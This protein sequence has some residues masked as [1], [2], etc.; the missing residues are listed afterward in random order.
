M[1]LYIGAFVRGTNRSDS[2]L[3]ADIYVTKAIVTR[4]DSRHEK[5]TRIK[6]LEHRNGKYIGQEFWVKSEDLE[7]LEDDE[8]I[9]NKD[10]YDVYARL[11]NNGKV[12]CLLQASIT[13]KSDITKEAQKLIAAILRKENFRP[14]L[15]T[16]KS[17]RRNHNYPRHYGFIGDPTPLT[18][19]MGNP[20]FVGDEVVYFKPDNST[21]VTYTFVVCDDDN[22]SY[23]IPGLK[24]NLFSD[25]TMADHTVVKFKSY[26]KIRH[27]VEVDGI[28]AV[29]Q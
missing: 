19:S 27:G 2:C 29:M 26:T 7:L 13:S 10:E 22:G 3:Y 4:I 12:I 8:I 23:Y 25:G 20:L 21:I 5:D 28:E 14:Y 17:A 24:G 1:K 16:S 15:M 9:I 6:I 18:D 11:K